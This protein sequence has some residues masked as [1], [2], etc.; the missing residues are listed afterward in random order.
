MIDLVAELRAALVASDV[1]QALADVFRGIVV[2]EVRAA[3]EQHQREELLDTSGLAKLLGCTP[4]ALRMRLARGSELVALALTVEGRRAWKRSD[5]D[6]WLA[7]AGHRRPALRL[8][9]GEGE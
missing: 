9:G 4:R 6:G 5:V 8:L 1:R 3:L 7:R 2:A